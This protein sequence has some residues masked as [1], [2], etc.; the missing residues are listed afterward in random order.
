[1]DPG[2]DRRDRDRPRPLD[3]A[4]RALRRQ[5][6]RLLRRPDAV[7]AR[8]LAEH[9]G[10]YGVDGNGDGRRSPYDPADAIPAAA[11]YLQRRRRPGDYRRAIF[12]YN[13]ADWYVADVLAKADA[14]RGAAT[15][16]GAG[17]PAE[18]ATVARAAAPTRGSCSRPASAP[19][20]A[21]AAST[22]GC[23]PRSPG[24]A[25]RHT[26]VVTA[27]RADHYP[28]TNHEAGR[29]MDIGAVDGE[30]CR[31]TRTGRC[32]DLVRELAAVTGPTALDRAHLLLG[33]RRPADPRQF[34]RADHCD[35]IH[36][37]MDA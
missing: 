19:T 29:A 6:L 16:R 32:A 33:P 28:G 12:A 8:R 35:H 21:P 3:R 24:S 30:I 36:W 13:H 27:L 34:A 18:T 7:L 23:S 10:R 25:A 5:R 37:G 15:S 31:G 9:L 1:M 11:R 14:Y 20:C 4:R 2:R 17:S 22:R 26:V